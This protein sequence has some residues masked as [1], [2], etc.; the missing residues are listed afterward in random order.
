MVLKNLSIYLHFIYSFSELF[1]TSGSPIGDLF[2]SSIIIITA[3]FYMTLGPSQGNF[4]HSQFLITF[5]Q[6]SFSDNFD[7]KV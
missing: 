7:V 6:P 3:I 1:F 5:V 2:Y 4:L